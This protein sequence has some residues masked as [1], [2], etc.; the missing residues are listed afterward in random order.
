[1]R[2]TKL[3]VLLT[4]LALQA[5]KQ[6]S[7]SGPLDGCLTASATSL[8][9]TDAQCCSFGCVYGVCTPNPL[10]GGVCRTHADCA[11]PRFCLEGTCQTVTCV[12]GGVS[13]VAGAP[14]C[15]GTCSAGFCTVDRAPVA[16]AGPALAGA[17]VPYRIPIQLA[18]ASYDPDNVPSNSGLTYIWSVLSAPPGAA[19]TFDPAPGYATPRFTPTVANAGVPYVL[20]LTVASGAA[21]SHVDITFYAVN[22]LPEIGM[23]ADIQDPAYQSRN[24]PLTFGA[25]VRDRDGGPVTCRWAKKG[26][27]AVGYTQVSGPVTCAGAASGAAASGVSQVT[28]VEDQAGIWELQLGADDGVNPVVSTSRFVNVQ[29]DP[30]V[31]NAGP[32]RWGNLGLD[33]IPLAGT[34]TDPNFDVTSFTV[35]DSTFTWEWKVTSAPVGSGQLGA[36][37]ATT[38]SALFS[39]D[40]VGTYALTLTCDD[41]NVPPG[42]HGSV[43]T[44]T[45]EVQVEPYM[46]PLG[47]V[48]DAVLVPGANKLVVA[49]TGS[50]NAYRLQI[51]D[52]ASLSPDFVVTL[53]AK[54]TSVGLDPTQ[55]E[56]LVG[57]A[58][59]RWQ[60]VTGIPGAPVVA[61]TV[62][63]VQP[64]TPP[65][66]VGIAFA[67]GGRNCAFG[68]TAGGSVYELFP[69]ATG[70]PWSA[71]AQCSSCGGF[72]TRPY[73][74][75]G[76]P[77]QEAVTATATV[78]GASGLRL[79][80]R[81]TTS[82]RIARYD[83]N[84]SNCNLASPAL[85]TDGANA[86]K[87]GLWLSSDL[88]DLFIS[89]STVYDAL[90]TAAS[91]TTAAPNR[92]TDALPAPYPD[93][94]A[95]A[96]VGG[97][98]RGAVAQ[99]GSAYLGTFTRAT[100]A[101]PYTGAASRTFPFFG[102]NGDKITSS[103]Q[104]AFVKAD[105]TEYYAIVR[106][107]LPTS[108]ATYRWFLVNLGP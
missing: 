76:F 49:D 60:L 74:P 37:V 66:F 5:C 102:Y 48:A 35:G 58:G 9:S 99:V 104:L 106:A 21:S 91:S 53:A 56:A 42:P 27:T 69:G 40:H 100:V 78:G 94:L 36:V 46:L 18:N 33:A 31:A 80:L 22:T 81:D 17:S 73:D 13:C 108:P 68:V 44:S 64:A 38:P 19:T 23:P 30:P 4:A 39:P 82:G 87:A 103:G 93:H 2:S 55:S 8:C 10:A 26:P 15:S 7:V 61:N 105:G 43:G 52:A 14:C 16:V 29:N 50:G 59:G 32:K 41:H 83:V 3:L 92:R 97:E 107:T 89:S 45:V 54:P 1:M 62:A 12:G 65:D 96:Y 88:T 28:L 25:T 86:G 47:E 77:F 6:E 34:A 85:W 72:P 75:A 84:T 79:W 51:V 57:V 24:V 63:T 70:A 101:G 98:L 20:R 95:T 11:A 90:S 71:A 67:G